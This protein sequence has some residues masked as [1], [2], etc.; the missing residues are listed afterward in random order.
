MGKDDY[1]LLVHKLGK[2]KTVGCRKIAELYDPDAPDEKKEANF[3]WWD[4]R[5][6]AQWLPLASSPQHNPL[7]VEVQS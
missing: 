6:Q 2:S 5:W 4:R 7:D 1:P 3:L